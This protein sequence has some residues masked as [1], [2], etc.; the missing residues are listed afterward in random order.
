MKVKILLALIALYSQ[1]YSQS[2][3]YMPIEF[4]AAYE[5][6][7]R[8]YD[9]N[10]GVN[11]WQNFSSYTITAEIEPGSWRIKGNEKI[12]YTNNSPDSLKSIVIKTYPNHYKKGMPRTNQVP[13]ETVTDGMI[14]TDFTIDN[15]PVS[16]KKNPNVEHFGTYIQVHLSNPILPKD[17]VTLNMN[18]TTE[19][20]SKYVNRIG[21]YN[22]NSAFV[23]YW[24]PQIARYDDIDKWDKIE[25]L[26]TQE[27]NTDF[28]DFNVKIKVPTGY[29]IWATGSLQNPDEVLSEKE[30]KRYRKA[31]TIRNQVTI[32]DGN[33]SPTESEGQE[34][35]NYKA[36]NVKDFAF[37]VSNTFKWIS[38]TVLVN[39]KAVMSNLVYDI[40]ENNTAERLLESQE[41]S[42][43]FLSNTSPG[44]TYPYSNFT[45]FIGVAEFDGM[46]FP[47]MANNG[48]SSNEVENTDVT[49]HE[50][51]HSY[52]PFFLGINEV[53]YSWMEEGWA[54]FF[55]TKFIQSYYEG[56]EDENTELNRNL[57]AYNKSAGSMWDVPLIT[58]SYLLTY[59]PSHS[60]LSYR[61]S[62]F[63]YFTLEN[64]LGEEIF[65]KCL[66]GYMNTWSGKH[67]TPYDFMFTFSEISNQN[68]DW[69]WNAWIFVPGYGD[70]GLTELDISNSKIIIKNVGGLPLPIILKLTYKD[71][72]EQL[73]ERTAKVWSQGENT[74]AIDIETIKNVTSIQLVTTHY[75]DS[76]KTNNLLEIKL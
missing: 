39:D 64:M 11:Y 2:R 72:T 59:K 75:P 37:G 67:P 8:A 49:F 14:I 17:S 23:G 41:K 62:A 26:G 56:G 76:D 63:M 53:K 28:A 69:F 35:W 45:T 27:F 44:V 47:M 70:L 4:Q 31:K 58:P 66:K 38:N 52:F 19:M 12:V 5:N 46:E 7:T 3:L 48:L 73:I 60:Q 55:T 71:G 34:I 9:G 32:I 42:L 68:L 21:A 43:S 22:D 25:Y 51:A 50:L 30:L 24:Y 36:S 29:N 54:T 33:N 6:M 15:V 10:P 18:W 40:N 16:I 13:L 61:K 20:P 65:Q 57:N 1:V 74:I